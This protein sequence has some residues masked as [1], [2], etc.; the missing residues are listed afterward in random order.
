MRAP[1]GLQ[2]LHA[3]APYG[4]GCVCHFGDGGV[5]FG[6]TWSIVS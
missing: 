6:S 3:G 5:L 2:R 1:Y 4:L